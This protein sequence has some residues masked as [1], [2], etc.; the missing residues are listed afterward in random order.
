[1]KQ[2]FTLLIAYVFLTGIHVWSQSYNDLDPRIREH[3]TEMDYHQIVTIQP[4]KLEKIIFLYTASYIIINLNCTDCYQIQPTEI[5][6]HKYE[7]FRKQSERFRI[8][9]NRNG[10]M[11]ELLS[12]DELEAQYNLIDNQ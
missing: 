9:L 1:M 5:D 2:L 6:I 11:L 4:S 12:R 7:H 3:Y 10:D 8:G